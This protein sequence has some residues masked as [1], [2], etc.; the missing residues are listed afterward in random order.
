M[1]S[2]GSYV[3]INPNKYKN[4][5]ES[6]NYSYIHNIGKVLGFEDGLVVVEMII[7]GNVIISKF[8]EKELNILENFEL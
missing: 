6:L 2:K 8:E 1:L 5:F 3:K 7:E 4:G